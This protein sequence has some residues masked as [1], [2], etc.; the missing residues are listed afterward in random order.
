VFERITEIK[1]FSIIFFVEMTE[2]TL[3]LFIFSIKVEHAKVVALKEVDI[4]F[5]VFKFEN[6]NKTFK[7]K[8]LYIK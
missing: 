1:N 8:A 3:D 5:F 4:R 6:C 2:N 7:T